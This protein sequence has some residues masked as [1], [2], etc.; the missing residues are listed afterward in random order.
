MEHR[1]HCVPV[2]DWKGSISREW[3][4][5]AHTHADAQI[6]LFILGVEVNL[7]VLQQMLARVPYIIT[8]T[9]EIVLL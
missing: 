4:L 9:H 1:Y 8:N 7:V 6:T 2:S 5:K 3:H